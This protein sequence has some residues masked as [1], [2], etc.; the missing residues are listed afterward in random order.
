ML[1]LNTNDLLE[2]DFNY[3]NLTHV[4]LIEARDLFHVH[5]MNKKN[6]VATAI[7][8]YR[9]RKAE[10]D[11][12]KPGDKRKKKVTGER[13]LENSE[14][15]SYSWPAILV[16]VKEWANDKA[17][18]GRAQDMI[19][20]CVYMPDG[21]VAPICV[22]KASK[23][24]YV[25]QYVDPSTI[26]FPSNYIGGGFPLIIESQGV[27]R[28]ASIGCVVHD[29]H[30]YYA[31]TN[32]HVAGPEGTVVYTRLKG[33][34]TRIG[35]SSGKQ[36]G[37]VAFESLYP[38]WKSK[39]LY[40]NND[41][42]LIEIDDLKQWKG[43]IFG[44]GAYD[45]V[46]DLNTKNISLRLIGAR[47][48]AFGAV[49]GKMYGEISAMFY[50]YKSVGGY[51]YSADF[52]IGPRDGAT[53]LNTRH[54]DSGTLWVLE[55][56]N[57]ETK[58]QTLLPIAVQWGQHSFLEDDGSG[59]STY[60]LATCLSNV[61]RVL[62]V[63]VKSDL[64]RGEEYSWGKLG[65]FSIASL[66]TAQVS[67]P[68][69]KT[70]MTNNLDAITFGFDQLTISKIQ[71]QLDALKK[72]HKFVPLADV[73]DLVWKMKIAGIYRGKE[74][75]NHFADMD[76]PDSNKETLLDKCK[77]TYKTMSFLTPA[78]WLTY[79][80]DKAVQDSSKGVLPFRVW[81][82]YNDMVSFARAGKHV[83]FL[84]AA[85][86][87]SHYVGD[88]CQPLHISYMFNGIPKANGSTIG[89]G[90]HSV[91]EE[92]MVNKHIDDILTKAQAKLKTATLT[93][94]GSG[95]EAAG[96]IVQMMKKVFTK[97]DPAA[98]S[99]L[100]EK[101]KGDGK[102]AQ[103]EQMWKVV[104]ADTMG[105]LFA[106]GIVCLASLWQSAWKNG[107]ADTHITELDVVDMEDLRK[108]YENQD[109]L[110]SVNIKEISKYT[111]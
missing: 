35:K 21:R 2:G 55:A 79:Y 99:K 109:F 91:F 63:D 52:L 61:L 9:I 10:A 33:V 48:S 106:E 77:G 66:A 28:V 24:D 6:V 31:L 100:V 84:A 80:T 58:A 16:F 71:K 87:L 40:I 43:D 97:I 50:R 39:D 93:D 96:L 111:V 89:E 101:Y 49:S 86:I 14:V 37:S 5:L 70:F 18:T 23:S 8:R 74:K 78:Q 19:P 75:P 59:S 73:P 88:S 27:E 26:V 53:S 20:K 95:K 11:P 94:V 105:T 83:E 1:K 72:Q 108:T 92:Q 15:R 46:A 7:G 17:F 51:E 68:K 3:S 104:G 65:H 38:G 67:K 32:K 60:G 57:V 76:K 107:Q 62:E 22:I 42:G 81:Q 103:A 25:E 36:I 47:V 110:P 4:D 82:I 98:L 69:L 90:V 54:G 85:G 30:T 12:T 34:L 56:E 64:N 45:K 41:I 44:L 29:G 13:T 102:A